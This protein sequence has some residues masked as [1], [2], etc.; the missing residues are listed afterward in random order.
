MKT[1]GFEIVKKYEN[2]GIRLPQRSTQQAAGYDIESA[3]TTTLEAGQIALVPTGVKAYMLPD[4]VLHLHD[5][6]S[7]PRKKGVVLANSVG[8]VDAD[9]YNNPD[10]EG[11]LF[12][13]FM[14]ITDHA[15]TI[16]K[17]D[18][19][20]QGVFMKYLVADD[21]EKAEKL[22]RSGGFGSTGQ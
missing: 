13:Q 19:I 17:G 3:V 5:R 20:M 21:D 9:Y 1:R 16:E 12:A 11:E 10:N 7:N 8:V 6:S 22:T 2:T 4:E 14:N 18:R 15:V